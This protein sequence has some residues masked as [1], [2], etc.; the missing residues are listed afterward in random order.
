VVASLEDGP[1]ANYRLQRRGP[2]KMLHYQLAAPEVRRLIEEFQPHIINPHFA[3]GYGFL[4]ALARV[5]LFPPIL[6]HAWGSDILL[7]PRKSFLHRR[8]TRLALE[9][10]DCVVGDS[11][12]LLD[13]A[14]EFAQLKRRETIVWGIERRYLEL[15]RPGYSPH[16]PLRVIVPRSQER[17]Y[18]NQFVVDA[19][20]KTVNDG[21][22]QLTFAGFGGLLSEF[23]KTC[24]R[25][26]GDRVRFYDKLPRDEY[27]KLLAEQDVY[28]SAARSDSSPASLLEAMGLGL[29]PVLGDI[30]G[31]REWVNDRT[32]LLFDLTRKQS[33][34]EAVGR[35][36]ES[37]VDLKAMRQRNVDRVL[38]DAVFE[39]N[40][41]RTI[42]V[43]H[44]LT[45]MRPQ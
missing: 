24:R 7:V 35:V 14:A 25:L 5:R 44:E 13:R 39:E 11:E 40:I 30:P 9:A 28:L 12:Y 4:A 29:I 6:L 42:E 41:A 10:A 27:M 2:L 17:V 8:K 20:A 3:S 45:G 21:R 36:L 18:N 37:S 33:L 19:L 34:V 1:V 22:I 26:A 23:K 31:V 38:T 15:R 43:M 16:Q 32:G